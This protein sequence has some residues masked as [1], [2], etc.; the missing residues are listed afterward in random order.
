[1][2]R[3]LPVLAAEVAGVAEGAG[4][5]YLEAQLLNFQGEAR[6]RQMD[7]CTSFAITS[8]DRRRTVVGQNVDMPPLFAGLNRVM[9]ITPE[10]GPPLLIWGFV[11][12]VGQRGVNGAG[13]ALMG[14]GL[15]GPPWGAGIASIVADRVALESNTIDEA[16][17]RVR[18]LTRAK[19]TNMVMADADGRIVD[20]EWTP[21]A[22]RA[23]L[24]DRGIAHT[25]CYLHPDLIP[26]ERSLPGIDDGG[27]RQAR[28]QQLLDAIDR[29]GDLT[30]SMATMLSD[31]AGYPKSIC[32]HDLA[33]PHA[34]VSA[35]S[36]I[37]VL[38]ERILLAADG[39]PCRATYV[40]F[41]L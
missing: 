25:N 16:I 9:R 5:D 11:G 23:L 26:L 30:T 10:R 31:H 38:P 12:T 33:R 19:A 13:L 14:N 8:N 2:E 15:G 27:Y 17:A 20:V 28:A 35:A 18:D 41:E 4:I 29:S 3:E 39:G 40:T 36:L 21:E 34:Y 37:A 32:R 6:L 24:S 7:G 1:M 22:D